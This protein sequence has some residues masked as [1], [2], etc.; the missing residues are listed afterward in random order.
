M[1]SRPCAACQQP[2]SKLCSKCHT[3]SYCNRD[4]QK[5]DWKKHKKQCG[6]SSGSSQ[7]G[8]DIPGPP[9]FQTHRITNPAALAADLEDSF[10]H[11]L[12]KQDVYKRL[13]DSFRLRVEDMV[14]FQGVRLGV[15]GDGDPVVEFTEFLTLAERNGKL[16]PKWWDEATKAECLALGKNEK[17]GNY[18]GY[19]LEKSDVQEEYGDNL[20]PMKLRVL[21]EKIYGKGVM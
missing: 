10:L 9:V 14:K 2:A 13:I 1:S 17:G 19:F 21:A 6:K 4:C 20:M 16:L 11:K 3:T 12:P 7:P 8:P 5:A 18:L 15:Y